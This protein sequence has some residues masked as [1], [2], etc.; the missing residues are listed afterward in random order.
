[1]PFHHDEMESGRS[2]FDY[3]FRTIFAFFEHKY[4]LNDQLP[5]FDPDFEHKI[6]QRFES[7]IIQDND[8]Y[9]VAK[10]TILECCGPTIPEFEGNLI[11]LVNDVPSKMTWQDF[12]KY[13]E[14]NS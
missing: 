11:T 14:N 5:I 6:I 12:C 7:Y 13:G 9:T 10:A 2:D 8:E 1:M 4:L 3:I